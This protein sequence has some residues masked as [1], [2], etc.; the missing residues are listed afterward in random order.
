MI[1]RRTQKPVLGVMTVCGGCL[2]VA[3][4]IVVSN[5]IADDPKPD[6]KKPKTQVQTEPSTADKS[7]ID[8]A[9]PRSEAKEKKRRAMTLGAKLEPQQIEVLQ[10]ASVEAG[11]LAALAGLKQN[12][13]II[14]VDGQ[15]ITNARQLDAYLASQAGRSVAVQIERDGRRVTLDVSPG[16][17]AEDTAWL[18]V[19]LDQGD[20]Q[21]KSKG[22]RITHVYP[23]GPAA[24]AGLQVDDTITKVDDQAIEHPADLILFVQ[25][26][27]PKAKTEFHLLRDKQEVKVPVTLGSRSAFDQSAHHAQE[28][29][30]GG[31]ASSQHEFENSN[32]SGRRTS[33]YG[34]EHAFH[35]IPSYAM[36][37][38]N[39]RRN[40]EQHERIE[41]EIRA[42]REEFQQFRDEMLKKK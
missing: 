17:I 38:E 27:A 31:Q 18:G 34:S 23:A 41:R 20:A 7:P 4:A 35:G 10:I 9:E 1:D 24:R 22:A 21:G 37:L 42:L 2:I 11:S 15:G 3:A 29:F 5:A 40:G 33:D 28:H 25:E 30:Q 16:Q 6:V 19:Y 26:A 8:A 32:S 14:A 12:D 13:R 36:E 39:E